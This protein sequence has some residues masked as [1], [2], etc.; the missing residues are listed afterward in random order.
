MK[1]RTV[2]ATLLALVLSLACLTGCSQTTTPESGAP[3]TG[4]ILVLKVNPEIAVEYNEAG[5]VTGVTARNDDAL[6]IIAGCEGL[7][8]SA[9]RNAVTEL[10]TAIGKA[11]YFVEEVEGERRRITIEIEA[12]SRLPHDTFLDEVVADVRSCVSTNAWS[13]PMDLVNESDYGMTSYVDTDYGPDNDGITDYT[14]YG[15]GA[16]GVTDYDHNLNGD[17]DY[18]PGNDGVTDYD[19]TDY[20][21]NT[22]YG[23][24]ADGNTDSNDSDYGVWGDGVTNSDDTDYGPGSDGVT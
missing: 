20:A 7:I 14:D 8:G 15:P 13:V 3:T 16:D 12:G 21:D 18:G 24:N 11:G 4:G 23:V 19:G 22:D 10:V 17:T 5:I 6:A 1:K 2:I 9:T